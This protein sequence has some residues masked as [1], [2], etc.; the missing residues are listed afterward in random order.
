MLPC[1]KNHEWE[2]GEQSQSVGCG[3]GLV[4]KLPVVGVSTA[5][6]HEMQNAEFRQCIVFT[7]AWLCAGET[8]QSCTRDVG[9]RPP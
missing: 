4:W 6:E 3:L 9:L 1:C 2:V 8:V 5:T 7:H